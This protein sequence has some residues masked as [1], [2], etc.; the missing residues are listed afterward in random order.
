VRKGEEVAK[1]GQRKRERKQ[2]RKEQRTTE[3]KE[4]NRIK[5]E[6]K[7]RDGTGMFQITIIE[8]DSR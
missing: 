7:K 6:V 3:S 1:A 8:A 5:Q 4:T 2:D